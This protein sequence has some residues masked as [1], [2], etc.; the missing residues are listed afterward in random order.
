MT[1][2]GETTGPDQSPTLIDEPMIGKMVS[3]YRVVK[4]LGQG[5]MGEV[6]LAMDTVLERAVALKF[7]TFGADLEAEARR[8]FLRE[9]KAAASLD[10]PFICDVHEVGEADGKAFIVMEYVDGETLAARLKRGSL[11]IDEAVRIVLEVAEAL[12]RAHS[13]GIVHRDL[14][15]GNIM[16]TSQ[17]HPKVMDFGLAKHIQQEAGASAVTTGSMTLTR[18][19][20][21][22]GTPAYMSPEQ[23]RGESVDTRS[24]IFSL[25]VILYESLT[26]TH[27]FLKNSAIETLSSVLTTPVPPVRMSGIKGP[28]RLDQ[29]QA[30]A[31]AKDRNDRYQGTGDLIADLR[32]FEEEI[33]KRQ[34]WFSSWRIAAGLIAIVA[35]LA[36]TWWMARRLSQPAQQAAA[37]PPISVLIGDFDN[38]TGEEVFDGVL[39]RAMEVGLEGAPFVTSYKRSVARKVAQM[40]RPDASRLDKDVSRLVAQREGISV[41]LDGSISRSD[42]S[43]R[44]SAEADDSFS[45]KPLGNHQVIARNKDEVLGAMAKL[46][47]QIRKDLGDA[48]PESA[49]L[50]AAETFTAASL[51]A[52]HV[53]AVGQDLL[54]RGKLEDAIR[55]Y[56][57]AVQLDPK[58]GRA[59]AGLAVACANLKRFDQADEYYKK[60]LALLDRMSEREK[61][62]TL[63]TYYSAY[64]HNF[65]QAIEAYQKLVSLY[66]GDGSG[67]NN[68]SIA[69]VY[70]LNIPEALA[71]SRHALEINSR[72]LQYRLNFTLYS[73][74]AGDYDNAIAEAR[75]TLKE[76]PT[77]EFAYLPLALST[78]AR[79]DFQEARAVYEQLEKVSPEGFS[80]AK[81]GEADLEMYLGRFNQ[82]LDPL[83][84]GI[85]ADEKEKNIGELALKEVAEAEARLA[86]GDRVQAAKLAVTAAELSRV[87]SVLLPAARVLIHA[88][89]EGKARKI[90]ETLEGMLQT[91]TRSYSKLILGEIALRQG[92]F[93]EALAVLR[94]AKNL[95]NSWLSH[96]LLG[97]TYFEA[98]HYGEALSELE[99]CRKRRGETSDLLF[100]DTTTLR[101]L[102]PL[103]YWLARTQEALGNAV[104]AREGYR[105][106]LKLR[107]DADPG[108]P[109]AADAKRR[110][111][112]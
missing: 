67:W 47:A 9:A 29:I 104:A 88:A 61:Y 2:S 20:A 107:T 102:P 93:S 30:R 8:R 75:K 41:V 16:L 34:G 33:R 51:D 106:F 63:G 35:L 11:P 65:P 6:F 13:K 86:S 45:G 50:A 112:D 105:E 92:R 68:L 52:A 31:L 15:P 76:D 111:G 25:G 94:E 85:A 17:G 77:Y 59:Y 12:E 28:S 108:D 90:A 69:Y 3:H 84:A 53:Y 36:L 73:M 96:Y 14:K 22:I 60:A 97:R 79:G 19:G 109:L 24:D 87:E 58:L 26:G 48:T 71:A 103:Y 10:H 80:M 46:A 37:Q 56:Q 42:S 81:M 39:E 72:S 99:I 54:E 98:G 43:Y 91:Q 78:L 101:Y 18:P 110:V 49:R 32:K 40:I 55:Y 95:H 66:P 74:Y 100:A 38:R 57:S 27:P 7:I 89:Q 82:A 62:R 1:S 23:A 64:Q 21:I 5:G 4:K 44:I 70:T 83:K